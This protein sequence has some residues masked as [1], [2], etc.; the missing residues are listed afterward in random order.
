[1]IYITCLLITLVSVPLMA[2]LATRMGIVDRPDGILKTHTR[3]VPYLG[4]LGMFFGMIPFLWRDSFSLMILSISLSLGLLDDILSVNPKIRLLVEFVLAWTISW[5]FLGLGIYQILFAVGIVA[6]INAVN[7]VDGMD[8]MAAGSV[9]I[10]SF[11]LA[12]MA[13][14]QFSRGL[15]LTILVVSLGFL[16]YNFPPAKIFMGDA[17]SYLLGTSLSIVLASSMRY[18]FSTDSLKFLFPVWIYLLDLTA[19]FLRR[20]INHRSP[21]S[22]DREHFY[23]K[24]KRIFKSDVKT[25]LASY[26]IVLA[27]SMVSLVESFYL[28]LSIEIAMSIFLIFSL[29]L[30]RYET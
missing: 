11:F 25:L 2:K 18:G 13:E 19:G 21:F 29:K 27:F 20:I 30:L 16:V 6:L 10:S 23:D 8:G 12:I 26:T 9:V 3:V 17:G 14:N 1:M 7:M 4:G 15:S 5:R 22:G 24:L 28:A